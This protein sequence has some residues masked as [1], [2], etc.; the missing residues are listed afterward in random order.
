MQGVGG[1]GCREAGCASLG[2]KEARCGRLWVQG[3]RV[4]QPGGAKRQ[5]GQGNPYIHE[6]M[7][8]YVI[9][10]VHTC[11]HT[12]LPT[13]IHAYIFSDPY[14]DVI[15]AYIHTNPACTPT[16]HTHTYIP[17]SEAGCAKLRKGVGAARQGVPSLIQT[18]LPTYIRPFSAPLIQVPRDLHRTAGRA[19]SPAYGKHGYAVVQVCFSID[20]SIQTY[21][22]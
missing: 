8:T 9:T 3:G 10:Y 5:G 1:C 13:Y 20:S 16:L 6:H 19:R 22:V 15:H 21:H 14:T 4:C 2:C 18:Y 12:Q 7:R 17:P 11:I